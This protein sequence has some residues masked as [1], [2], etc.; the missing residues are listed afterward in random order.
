MII[1]F[2]VVASYHHRRTTCDFPGTRTD[3]GDCKAKAA[4]ASVYRKVG[5]CHG[6]RSA[7]RACKGDTLHL[8]ISCS[9]GRDSED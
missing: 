2:S 6:R 7:G 9:K 8:P 4:A 1:L 5:H 3:E